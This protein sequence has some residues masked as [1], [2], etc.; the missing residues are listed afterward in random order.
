M[1]KAIL[2]FVRSN[3]IANR[4]YYSK[5]TRF[6]LNPVRRLYYRRIDVSES[7]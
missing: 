7:K 3:R 2:D 1:L 6:I 5:L 4:L